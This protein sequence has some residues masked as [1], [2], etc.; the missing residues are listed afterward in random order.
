MDN[1]C[2]CHDEEGQKTT[3]AAVGKRQCCQD[4]RS[5]ACYQRAMEEQRSARKRLADDDDEPEEES[6]KEMPITFECSASRCSCNVDECG[7]RVTQVCGDKED[8][9]MT[10]VTD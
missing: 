5:C 3:G 2:A 1:G 7:L 10:C 9:M 6:E 8:V 4:A